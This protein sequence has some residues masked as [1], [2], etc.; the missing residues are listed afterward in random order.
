MSDVIRNAKGEPF[1]KWKPAD[2]FAYVFDAE[3][4]PGAEAA[5]E[6][7]FDETRKWRFDFAWPS[8]KVAVEIDGFGYGHQAQQ[9]IAAGHEKQNA[10]IEQGWRVL[11]F[12]SRQLGSKQGVSDA[13]EQVCRLLC[14]A[15]TKEATDGE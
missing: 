1:S 15:T 12:T 7:A 6:F 2:K 5:N 10:A 11:R 3:K 8:Q 4:I 14:G 13:V 9:N